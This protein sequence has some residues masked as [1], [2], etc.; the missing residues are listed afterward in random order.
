LWRLQAHVE[1]EEAPVI[2]IDLL[3]SYE[4]DVDA[5]YEEEL[6]CYPL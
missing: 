6:L 5:I 2:K 1:E 3:V 4:I